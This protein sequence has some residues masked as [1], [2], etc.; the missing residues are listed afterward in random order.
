[1]NLKKYTWIIVLLAGILCILVISIPTLFYIS[2]SDPQYNRYYWLIGIY[3]DGEGTIDLLDD[4]PMIM[5]IGILGLIITLT[6]GIL[7]IISSSLSK[8]TEI[9]IPGTGIFWLIFGILLFTLPFLLQTLMGL[10]GGGE[11]TIFGLS[12]NLFGPITYSAGLL[13]IIAGLEELRT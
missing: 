9:N 11:G 1:M 6:I 4:A 8:F 13:T 3:L 2:E 12:V 10:I 7:L 5:N